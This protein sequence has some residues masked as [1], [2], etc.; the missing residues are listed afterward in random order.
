MDSSS[1]EDQ[2]Q[3][4]V[5]PIISSHLYKMFS[6]EIQIIYKKINEHHPEI[7][8]EQLN[9]I[10][11][12]DISTL[13]IKLGI[14]KR[15]RKKIDADKTCMGRKG[16]GLQCTRSRRDGSEYCLSHQKNLPHG[17]IDDTSYVPKKKGTRGR[18]RK[19][20]DL[21]DNKD[22]IPMVRTKINCQYY[23]VDPDKNVYT[24]HE[25]HPKKIGILNENNEIVDCN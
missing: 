17:R 11:N 12:L 5:E 8:I 6:D 25:E 18:R 23:L 14:K 7:T 20:H 10:Y 21:K 2:E 13:A 24:N 9:S 3:T 1:L 4:K 19:D 15:I 16:D 22:Y